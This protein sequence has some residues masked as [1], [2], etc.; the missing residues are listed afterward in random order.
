MDRQKIQRNKSTESDNPLVDII[1]VVAVFS[2]FFYILD[3][4]SRK[5]NTSIISNNARKVLD[6]KD[7]AL[8]RLKALINAAMIVK[9]VRRAT[10]PTKG[11]NL[12][13]LD[14]KKKNSSNKLLRAKVD[15]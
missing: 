2:A 7:D 10:K 13:R 12:R 5:T 3:A 9:K 4:F 15:H 8:K 1:G 6:N 11:S 14:S